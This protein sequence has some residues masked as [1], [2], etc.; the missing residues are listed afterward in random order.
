MK[1]FLLTCAAVLG[2]G[3]FASADEATFIA[4]TFTGQ[5]GVKLINKDG[6][7]NQGSSSSETTSLNGQSFTDADITITF[8]HGKQSN[9]TGA[10]DGEIRWYQDEIITVTPTPGATITKIFV[11]TVKNSKVTSKPQLVALNKALSPEQEQ[12]HQHPS[13][14]QAM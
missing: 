6:S 1:K 14:G 13:P 8:K 10:Y 7:T 2:I 4:P 9:Y 3:A 12:A 5:S 11:Q